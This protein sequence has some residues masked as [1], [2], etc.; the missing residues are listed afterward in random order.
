MLPEEIV[1]A[2]QLPTLARAVRTSRPKLFPADN[3]AG[4]HMNGTPAPAILA[5]FPAG[6]SAGKH[7]NF[8]IFVA[9]MM[10]PEPYLSDRRR[11][12]LREARQQERSV[13]R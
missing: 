13:K 11:L 1:E 8:G 9:L 12:P 3:P 6:L 10:W 2:G 7:M 4:K 5:L